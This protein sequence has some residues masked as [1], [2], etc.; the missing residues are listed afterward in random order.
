MT[1]TLLSVKE[2]HK[3]FYLQIAVIKTVINLCFIIRF[4]SEKVLLLKLC[5][6]KTDILKI[7]YL[8]LH[9]L[10]DPITNCFLKQRQKEDENFA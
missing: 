5:A 3:N 10:A 9:V 2:G 8:A 7:M 4:A 6:K 1:R